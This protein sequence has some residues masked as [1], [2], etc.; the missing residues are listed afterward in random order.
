MMHLGVY[1]RADKAV[2][3]TGHLKVFVQLYRADFNNFERKMRNGPLFSVCALIPFS[4]RY[5]VVFHNGDIIA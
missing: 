1:L 2:E 3:L 4:V 5:N